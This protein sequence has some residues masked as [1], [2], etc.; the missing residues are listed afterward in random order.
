MDLTVYHKNDTEFFIIKEFSFASEHMAE[1][2]ITSTVYSPDKLDFEIDSYV[3]FRGVKYS[4][5]NKTTGT[6]TARTSEGIGNAMKYDLV[7]YDPS[8]KLTTIGF[9]D[10]VSSDDTQQYYTG[11]PTFSFYNDVR[12]LGVRLQANLDR[13]FGIGV[14]SITIDPSVVFEEKQVSIANLKVWDGLAL[15][16]TTY[17]LDFFINGNDI[18]IGGT[19]EDLPTTFYYGKGKGLYEISRVFDPKTEVITRLKVYGAKDRNLP[20]AY[21]RDENS[22]GRYFDHLMLPDFATTGID[23]VDA[24]KYSIFIPV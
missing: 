7:F 3:M 19:G 6:K 12:E 13:F 24:V 23:Y 20:K 15:A 22:K 16:N 21:L 8:K 1:R 14:W 11:T 10:Y 18:V 9:D 17:G 5:F 2:K 4:I